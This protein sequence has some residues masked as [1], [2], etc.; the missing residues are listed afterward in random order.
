MSLTYRTFG[1]QLRFIQ[2]SFTSYPSIKPPTMTAK[3]PRRA[4]HALVPPLSANESDQPPNGRQMLDHELA[5]GGPAGDIKDEMSSRSDD[6]SSSCSCSASSCDSDD[7]PVRFKEESLLQS[8]ASR[9]DDDD[10]AEEKAKVEVTKEKVSGEEKVK[11]EETEKDDD[12][13]VLKRT[14]VVKEEPE[15]DIV[16]LKAS[17]EA[18]HCLACGDTY[19]TDYS[20]PDWEI[21]VKSKQSTSAAGGSSSMVEETVSTGCKF[22][23]KRSNSP[24]CKEDYGDDF[25]ARWEEKEN[26]G[27]KLVTVFCLKK[28]ASEPTEKI[29]TKVFKRK[30]LGSSSDL[31]W[32]AEKKK[33]EEENEEAIAAHKAFTEAIPFYRSCHKCTSSAIKRHKELKTA[34]MEDGSS[35]NATAN[36]CYWCNKRLYKVDDEAILCAAGN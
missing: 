27:G 30:R 12:I 13:F 4:V 16:A 6:S 29:F 20:T 10:N 3:Q 7:C 35:C 26:I 2:I 31:D 21:T 23:V 14:E 15:S 28:L 32:Q 18:P 24:I 36:R 8:H 19:Q 22:F 1:L 33:K 34:G 9:S 25:N 5:N 17:G 11:V